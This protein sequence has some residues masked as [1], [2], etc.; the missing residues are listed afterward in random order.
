[1]YSCK[2][3]DLLSLYIIEFLDAVYM[4]FFHIHFD[5]ERLKYQKVMG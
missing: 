3:A 1:M 4:L 2:D 5:L